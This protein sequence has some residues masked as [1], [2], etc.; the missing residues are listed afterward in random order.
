M[1][2][3]EKPA[4]I[5]D[6]K[7]IEIPG[8]NGLSKTR[9]CEKAPGKVLDVLKNEIYSKESGESIDYDSL[10]IEGVELENSNIEENSK[11]TYEKSIEIF[12]NSNEKEK[13]IFLGGDH[14]ISYPLTRAFF[15]YCQ[16][17]GDFSGEGGEEEGKVKEPCLIVFDAHPDLMPVASGAEDYPNHEEW[18][19]QLV[20]DG[21]PIENI[22][23]VGGRNFDP[24]ESEF[25]KEKGIK[26]M[27]IEG[28]FEDLAGGGDMIMEFSQGKELYVSLDIDVVDPAFA[29]GTGY[30]E[31]G[32]FSSRE[33]LYLVKR[34]NKIKNLKA[35]DLVEINPDKDEKH[36][37]RTVRLGARVLGEL[38]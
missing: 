19:R 21:F 25:I 1:E 22:L 5:K 24:Q 2:E 13:I 32:G 10:K 4:H 33:F 28:F 27:N 15:D 20:E 18:L 38:V 29:P 37:Y 26:T 35:L 17:P 6:T 7:V 11:K 12:R 31:V 14:S 8:I 16:S 23:L 3:I 9:G 30:T 34:I 36:N